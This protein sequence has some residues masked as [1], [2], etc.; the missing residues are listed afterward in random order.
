M[1][2]EY[3]IAKSIFSPEEEE[4]LKSLK[5][6]DYAITR[7]NKMASSTAKLLGVSIEVIKKLFLKH[8]SFIFKNPK[9][10][11]KSLVKVYGR[12][13][14]SHIIDLILRHPQ[15]ISYNH[16]DNLEILA[17]LYEVGVDEIKKVSLSHPQFLGYNH[18]RVI[19]QKSRLGRLIGLSDLE[20]KN[21]ILKHPI[22]AGCSYMRE[23]G[24]FDVVRELKNQEGIDI[25][26]NQI[27]NNYSRSPYVPNTN[28]LRLSKVKKNHNLVDLPPL[29]HKLKKCIQK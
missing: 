29:Y 6:G 13:N 16:K 2:L 8:P 19:K 28:R 4:E 9:D 17:K 5:K 20:V 24:I 14:K 10:S 7:A 3:M 27:L 15:F 23:L 22:S 25:N 11:I 26:L 1:G 21:L 12:E 18:T